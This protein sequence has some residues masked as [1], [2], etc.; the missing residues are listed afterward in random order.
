MDGRNRP[1]D[2]SF[3]LLM[4][5]YMEGSFSF[6]RIAGQLKQYLLD[7]SPVTISPEHVFIVEPIFVTYSVSVWCTVRDEDASFETQNLIISTLKEYLNP[8]SGRGQSGWPIGV[9]P[10]KAQILM[11]LG[12]LKSRA[13]VK[14]TVISVQYVD[15]DGEHV[16]DI[17]DVKVSP[18]MVVRSG[19][20]KAYIDYD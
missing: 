12:T 11:K 20:H 16:M 7:R 18:F 14:K 9:L 8:V 6:H 19:E 13:V 10:K 17:E 5:D 3:V 1:Q 15:K 4:K 2:I